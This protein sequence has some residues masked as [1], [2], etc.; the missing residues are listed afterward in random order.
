MRPSGRGWGT[1]STAESGLG[2]PRAGG[3]KGTVEPAGWDAAALSCAVGS[4]AAHLPC[5]SVPLWVCCERASVS[6][7]G[8]QGSGDGR[9]D[10]LVLNWV[11]HA[12]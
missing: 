4:R 1:A 8:E 5:A 2:L 10:A 9:G 3:D 6:P 7:G 12:W 11:L